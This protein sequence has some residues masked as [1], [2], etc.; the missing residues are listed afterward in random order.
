MLGCQNVTPQLLYFS[1]VRSLYVV[2]SFLSFFL[3]SCVC[4]ATNVMLPY[5]QASRWQLWAEMWQLWAEIGS[6]VM[7]WKHTAC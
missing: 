4:R 1:R 2:R 6:G 5:S 3:S 7:G